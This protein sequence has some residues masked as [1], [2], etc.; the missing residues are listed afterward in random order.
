M[1]LGDLWRGE[2]PLGSAFWTY[3][4]LIGAT[5][6]IAAT[7]A[8]MTAL[9]AGAHGVVGLAIHL[10]PLPYNVTMTVG[11]WRSAARHSASPHHAQAA[12]IAVVA[13]AILL[14]LL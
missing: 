10:S 12:R 4:V 5:A 13:W 1:R 2:L 7:A 14:S 9:A 6:N 11:V 8:M 3:A